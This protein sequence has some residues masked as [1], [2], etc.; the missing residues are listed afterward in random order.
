EELADAERQSLGARAERYLE[1]GRAT[2]IEYWQ[3]RRRLA[4]VR[5]RHEAASRLPAVWVKLLE[6]PASAA[7]SV[8]VALGLDLIASAMAG[9]P[10]P[11]VTK[12]LMPLGPELAEK[13]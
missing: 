8:C 9:Q 12:W 5:R 4:G 2:A 1:P 13:A 6:M 11:Q 10:S 7:R 3:R